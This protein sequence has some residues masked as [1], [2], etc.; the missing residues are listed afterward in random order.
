[1][2]RLSLTRAEAAALLEASIEG[3]GGVMIGGALLKAQSKL[4]RSFGLPD[5]NPDLVMA[6]RA[7]RHRGPERKQSPELVLR[8]QEAA[9]LLTLRRQLRRLAPANEAHI[10]DLV[11]QKRLLARRAIEVIEG[12][13]KRVPWSR[14]HRIDAEGWC[15]NCWLPPDEALGLVP[16]QPCPGAIPDDPAHS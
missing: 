5:P 9:R 1:M 12:M 8:R 10:A 13:L 16:G 11:R 4:A 14:V 3:L 2:N 7:T 6:P 15:I